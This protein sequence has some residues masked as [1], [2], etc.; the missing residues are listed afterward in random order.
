[1]IAYQK[2]KI[3]NAVC[4]FAS[5]HKEH[6]G[7]NLYQ[8]FLYKYLALFEFEYIKKYGR[9]PLGLKYLA[10]EKGPVPKEIYRKRDSYKSSCA[11]FRKAGEN[12]YI[13]VPT[14]RPDLDFFSA[15]ELDEMV[16]LIQIY[17]DQFVDT[18]LMS[19]A[20]HQEIKAWRETYKK[21]PNGEI[22]PKLTFGKDFEK[23]KTKDRSI[24]EEDYLIF[25]VI[26]EAGSR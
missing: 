9:P 8:T 11:Q 16:R 21:N 12:Q 13:V 7:R 20:S 22:D 19:E 15:A 3:E 1:M 25:K 23:K 18:K 2:E 17:A 4:F 14:A 24:A 10:M 5:K 6:T 26:E